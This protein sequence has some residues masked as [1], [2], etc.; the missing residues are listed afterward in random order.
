MS[1]MMGMK[2][3]TMADIAREAGVAKSTVSRYFNG[4]Y[5]HEDTREKLRK[6]IEKTNY[7]PSVAAQN[8][9]LKNTH[10]IGIVAP[11]LLS[12]VT[13]RQLTA[14]DK[15]LRANGYS[16]IIMN[17][18]HDPNREIA[19]IEYLRSMRTDG[20]IL[21]ATNI[22]EEHQRLQKSSPVPFLVMGQRFNE[23]TSVIYDDYEAGY[24]IGSYIRSKGHKNILYVGV[25]EFDDAV[26]RIRKQGVLDGLQSE[27]TNLTS[28]MM[29]ETTFSY[30]ETR[31]LIQDVLGVIEP[32]PSVIICAT[33]MMALAAHKEVIEKGFKIPE[34]ISIV[35]FGGYE[36]S[37]LVSPSIC[38]IRF[39]NEEAGAICAKTII[40]MIQNEPVAAVQIIGHRF[41]QGGSVFDLN[42]SE[43]SIEDVAEN[44]N[45]HDSAARDINQ[46]SENSSE[47]KYDEIEEK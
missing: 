28:L 5:L 21:I 37:E 11:T 17:T 1:I 20:I 35:G 12:T 27:Q 30:Q 2:K 24:E 31:D 7:E 4:G 47:I 16:T 8:L 25:S 42:P 32:T 15:T 23:G 46:V 13:G 45:G 40:S 39:N 38:S 10:T 34:D 33:D 44:K 19:A 36:I 18:D 14:M 43:K 3:Y 9:K 22:S 26:G 6:I 41:I 29:E